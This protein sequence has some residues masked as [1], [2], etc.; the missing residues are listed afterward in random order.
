MPS[1]NRNM[2]TVTFNCRFITPAF[3]GGA[4]PRGTPELRA[5]SIKGALRFWWR[6]QAGI[7]DIQKLRERESLIFG[8]VEGQEKAKKASFS[9]RV[10]HDDFD[11]GNQLPRSVIPTK[12]KGKEIKVNI[13]E[14]LAYGT[15]DYVKGT[16]RS[17]VKPDQTFKVIMSFQ[18]PK[19][20]NEVSSA[21]RL[22]ALFGGLGNRN[23]NGFGSFRIENDTSVEDW[24]KTLKT[25]RS[26]SEK[27]FN[28]FSENIICFQTQ[29]TFKQVN[30][31]WAEL[32]KAYKNARE[33]LDKPHHY[34]HRSYIASPIIENKKQTTFLD[35]HTKPYFVSIVPDSGETRGIILYLP[36]LFLEDANEMV[37]ELYKSKG[38]N[39]NGYW[40][41]KQIL[42]DTSIPKHQEY[43]GKSNGFFHQELCHQDNPY[44]L[45]QIN[46]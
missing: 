18:T 25:L 22:F 42:I 21:F 43:Y 20:I 37:N 9:I 10:V 40:N 28:S 16:N 46:L 19:Y 35:R 44:A 8:G 38:Q 12:V 7:S 23:R 1:H 11:L 33:Y 31:A 39:S 17:F 26:G 36:Y 32:G 30:D 15:F 13:F 45:T 2:E 3:L 4:D 6:A 24:G 5:P 14:Y 27:A 34:K 41:L 29:K